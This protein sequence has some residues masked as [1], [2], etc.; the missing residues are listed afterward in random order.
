MAAN[1]SLTVETRVQTKTAGVINKPTTGTL[2]KFAS[3]AT[4]D[5]C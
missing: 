3:G 2:I 1:G 5:A 4:R